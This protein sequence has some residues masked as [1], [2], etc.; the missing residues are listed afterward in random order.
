[1]RWSRG[2][3]CS[4][5][6]CVSHWLI[7]G[8]CKWCYWQGTNFQNNKQ[9]IQLNIEKQTTQPK[10]RQN[11]QVDIFPKEDIQMA[12]RH[13][14]RCTILW[15]IRKMHIKTTI[16][17]HLTPFLMVTIKNSI[18][19]KYSRTCVEMGTLLHCWWECELIQLLWKKNMESP[20]FKKLKNRVSIWSSNLTPGHI[21][22]EKHGSKGY[23]MENFSVIKEWNNGFAAT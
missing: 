4:V 17:Y 1:M 8:Y 18:N 5:C 20:S 16:E 15:I 11:T 19:N 7:C 2:F 10:N 22:G 14:K 21:S 3:Y 23:K 6:K 13:M 12:I 9:F